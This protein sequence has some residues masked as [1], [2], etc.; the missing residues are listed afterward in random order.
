MT[1]LTQNE[2]GNVV[3]GAAIEVHKEK[4][5]DRFHRVVNNL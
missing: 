2:L 5:K 4:V 3:I 1:T